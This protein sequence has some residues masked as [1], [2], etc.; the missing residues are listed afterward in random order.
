VLSGYDRDSDVAQSRAAGFVEHL[1]K[2]V[3]DKALLLAVQRAA[4]VSSRDAADGTQVKP[5]DSRPSLPSAA[6]PG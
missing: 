2:P 6:R 4:D 1:A 5:R 3:D